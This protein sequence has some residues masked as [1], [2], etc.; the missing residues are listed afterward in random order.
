MSDHKSDDQD[1]KPKD[2]DKPSVDSSDDQ[3]KNEEKSSYTKFDWTLEESTDQQIDDT[4]ASKETVDSSNKLE[5]K[6]DSKDKQED[7][8][9]TD[10][11]NN[12]DKCQDVKQNDQVTK[13]QEEVTFKHEE[14]NQTTKTTSITEIK[15]SQTFSTKQEEATV[16]ANKS[17]TSPSIEDEVSV[18][19]QDH[20][21][22]KEEKDSD[23]EI[24][25]KP[26]IDDS[27]AK[28]GDSPKQGEVESI[29]ERKASVAADKT[30]DNGNNNKDNEDKQSENDESAEQKESSDS[31]QNGISSPPENHSLVLNNLPESSGL[32]KKE[33]SISPKKTKSDTP[34]NESCEQKSQ[35][36]VKEDIKLKD[37]DSSEKNM[38]SS[39]DENCGT[40][41]S[42]NFVIKPGTLNLT[43]FKASDLINK[44]MIGKSDPFVK[45][46]FKG[47]EF[48]SK[49]KRNNLNPEWNFSTDLVIQSLNE[50]SDIDIEIFDDDFGSENS[51]GSYTL[52]LKQAIMDTNKEAA[53]HTLIGCKTGKISF[54]TRYSPEEEEGIN[55][56]KENDDSSSKE[57]K[58]ND[59]SNKDAKEGEE[60][61][62]EMKDSHENKDS[63]TLNKDDNSTSKEDKDSYNLNKEKKDDEEKKDTMKDT[64]ENKERLALKK[65]DETMGSSKDKDE[66]LPEKGENIMTDNKTELD[67]RE[68]SNQTSVP[69]TYVNGEQQKNDKN[70]SLPEKLTKEEGNDPTT[71]KYDLPE[72][73][74]EEQPIVVEM[75]SCPSESNENKEASIEEDSIYKN[76]EQEKILNSSKSND[77]ILEK[78]AED[79]PAVVKMI[80][81]PS[82][83][84][85]QENENHNIEEDKK[86]SNENEEIKD[87]M[88][89]F[90]DDS[91]KKVRDTKDIKDDEKK[92]DEMKSSQENEEKSALKEEDK[93]VVSHENKTDIQ[94]EKAEN[95]LTQDKASF[96]NKE[97][98]NHAS[99]P[100]TQDISKEHLDESKEASR[101]AD[102]SPK[103][104]E[105]QI[106]TKEETSSSKNL[107]DEKETA[108][109]GALGL[110]D[111]MNLKTEEE[112][113]IASKIKS[114]ESD[115]SIG[116]A[117]ELDILDVAKS[118]VSENVMPSV[119]DDSNKKSMKND[120]NVKDSKSEEHNDVEE[121]GEILDVDET[122]HQE[123]DSAS[124]SFINENDTSLAKQNSSQIDEKSSIEK[125]IDEGIAQKKPIQ[126]IHTSSEKE[127]SSQIDEE[128]SVEKDG[129]G[130]TAPDSFI[131][132]IYTTEG[133]Q[134]VSEQQP[135]VSDF[136]SGALQII[137]HK[138]VELVNKDRLGKSDPYVIV[139]YR[140]KEFRS[141][142]INNTLE[143]VWDFISEF[144]IMEI[145][146]SPIE[147]EVY[148]ED[149][150]K[151]SSEGSYSLTVDE[152]I[153]D[154]VVEGKWYTLEGCKTGKVFISAIYA[155]KDDEMEDSNEIKEQ[156]GS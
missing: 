127:D 115:F 100:K 21:P 108:R 144:E 134:S 98:S 49:K 77:G 13:V 38:S 122:N 70:E 22:E 62:D 113:N 27:S 105:E 69:E 143:P 1:Q 91:T 31:E 33:E 51:I 60:K 34:I 53:W 40:P 86:T 148:D 47:Q 123:K 121:I 93:K 76:S 150:G 56:M 75:I 152:A 48:K 83:S 10:S 28:I 73:T 12:Q 125:D 68:S 8:T 136:T 87:K 128:L 142:T 79:K 4:D 84:S 101:E 110:K 17:E 135:E 106:I 9:C 24:K 6:C 107:K 138:A 94:P 145:D 104:A 59:K 124:D 3:N 16:P 112:M 90:L 120:L 146:D 141:K 46:R 118:P 96:D 71:L 54:S 7:V 80:S 19:A 132:D 44:D 29:K 57:D 116:S 2:Q 32:L 18:I 63:S 37:D 81:C 39:K 111:M 52:S 50:K 147:I 99:E 156:K 82:E 109:T 131:N 43:V 14:V 130:D 72:K 89:D 140:D 55:D 25:D 139:K 151:D 5:E 66:I 36:E 65:E 102:L 67:K 117:K 155:P 114:E 126:N 23:R 85:N 42:D 133:K 137:V 35:P 11:K 58:E 149:Y 129:T 103:E 20:S 45:I 153:N 88:K 92:K 30:E 15:N 74:A 26:E 154:L 78:T 41:D 95:V 119:D 64:Q 97:S 61:K